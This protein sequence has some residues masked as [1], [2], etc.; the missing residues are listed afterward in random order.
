VNN[1]FGQI[2]LKTDGAPLTMHARTEDKQEFTKGQT[3]LI[4]KETT[5]GTFIVQEFNEI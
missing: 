1:T 4:T 2:E 5:P 3:V